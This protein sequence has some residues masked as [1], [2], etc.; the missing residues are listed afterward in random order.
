MDDFPKWMP[1]TCGHVMHYQR[2][3]VC[4]TV[5]PSHEFKCTGKRGCGKRGN[6]R[7]VNG[8][9]IRAI[10]GTAPKLTA[11]QAR[12]VILSPLSA[13]RLA[14]QLDV[15]ASTIKDIRIGRTYARHTADLRGVEVKREQEYCTK[16]IHYIKGS[17]SLGFPESRSPSYA[18]QCSTYCKTEGQPD[19][20]PLLN[21]A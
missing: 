10:A 16:C 6:Y 5:E 13:T 7:Y 4:K 21:A 17:C 12:A 20:E 11:E 15:H 3:R 1:C 18:S 9:F 8:E 2:S 14:A 19:P